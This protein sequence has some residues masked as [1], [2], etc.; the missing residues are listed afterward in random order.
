M[1]AAEALKNEVANGGIVDREKVLTTVVNGIRTN[2]SCLVWDPY[3][4]RSNIHYGDCNI[5]IAKLAELTAI[6]QICLEEGFHVR[7]AYHPASG[8][9]YGYE[10][11]L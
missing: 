2:G 9:C 3:T 1:K 11:S 6:K 7:N 5:E 10:I 8:R 4:G